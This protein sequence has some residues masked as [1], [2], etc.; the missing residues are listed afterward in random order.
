MA[1]E[2]LVAIERDRRLDL[3][4]PLERGIGLILSHQRDDGLWGPPE[5]P[6]FARLSGALKVLNR[7]YFRAGMSVPRVRHMLDTLLDAQARGAI[8]A[9]SGNCCIPWNTVHLLCYATECADY[10]RNDVHEALRGLA[11]DMRAWVYDDGSVAFD[12]GQPGGAMSLITRALGICGAYL[13]WADCPLPNALLD[14]E[15][16]I[17]HAYRVLTDDA[18]GVRLVAKDPALHA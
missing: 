16:G 13:N 10:R 9:S 18:G 7:L 17:G 8:F 15:R 4:E 3:I 6:L 11:R 14:G 2:I 1:M 5:A 12:R